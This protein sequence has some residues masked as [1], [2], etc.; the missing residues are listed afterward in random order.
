MTIYQQ[1]EPDASVIKSYHRDFT[2]HDARSFDSAE[3]GDIA[4]W[5]AGEF[6]T[7]LVFTHRKGEPCDPEYLEAVTRT[8]DTNPV[9]RRIEFSGPNEGR[10]I[11][12]RGQPKPSHAGTK[13]RS[14]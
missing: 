11:K 7:H 5:T 3:R 13:T 14:L 8:Y 6:G 4:I 12:L 9:W 10:V 2:Y 1:L